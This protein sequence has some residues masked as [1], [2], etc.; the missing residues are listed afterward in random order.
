MIDYQKTKVNGVN[1]SLWL[2]H[3]NL[4]FERKFVVKTGAIDNKAVAVYNALR[5]IIYYDHDEPDLVASMW[6]HGSLQM[7]WNFTN[8]VYAP[9]QRNETLKL[10]GYNGNN[11]TRFDFIETLN[12]IERLFY[13]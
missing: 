4:E 8:G 9:N 3:D 11:F 5:F 10:R 12:E 7:Y 6:I 1:P 13:V 2:G